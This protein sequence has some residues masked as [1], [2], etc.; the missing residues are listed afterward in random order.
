MPKLIPQ[1]QPKQMRVLAGG[2][3]AAAGSA[4]APAPN[5]GAGMGSSSLLRAL[6]SRQEGREALQSWLSDL[7]FNRTVEVFIRV[8]INLYLFLVCCPKALAMRPLQGQS[9]ELGITQDLS[10]TL[11][12]DSEVSLP[13]LFTQD[14]TAGAGAA[15]QPHR[16]RAAPSWPYRH[17]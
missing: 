6:G 10:L 2:V 8:F 5:T 7:D 12:W 16:S 1:R 3:A 15:V 11:P 14:T 17:C 4:V 9:T 13:P